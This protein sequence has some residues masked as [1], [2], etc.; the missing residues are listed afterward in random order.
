MNLLV[1]ATCITTG[2]MTGIERF[3]YHVAKELLRIDRSVEVISS[4][5]SHA[6]PFSPPP[7]ALQATIVVWP[8]ANTLRVLYRT[9]HF[10]ISGEEVEA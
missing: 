5:S 7:T 4:S 3:A 1:N 10:S 6:V 8:P 2:K 9:R